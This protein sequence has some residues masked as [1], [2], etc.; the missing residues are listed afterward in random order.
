MGRDASAS[1][2]RVLKG[3][4]DSNNRSR[5]GRDENISKVPHRPI[6]LLSVLLG[7]RKRKERAGFSAFLPTRRRRCV[8]V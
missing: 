6:G 4:Q 1:S 7:N 3:C 8:M 5:I 2:C